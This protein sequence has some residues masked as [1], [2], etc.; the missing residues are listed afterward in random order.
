MARHTKIIRPQVFWDPGEK[1]Y[2]VKTGYSEAYKNDL[3]V[4][5]DHGVRYDGI[6]KLWFVDEDDLNDLFKVLA[7]HWPENV[8][9]K[10]DFIP[11]PDPNKRQAPAAQI[12]GAGQAALDFV[13]SDGYEGART[14]Y[15]ALVKKYEQAW[16]DANN[17]PP[18]IKEK[19]AKITRAWQELKS[20]MGWS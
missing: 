16:K 12:N 14:L 2:A 19:A 7:A 17:C 20:H 5:M 4:M 8:Y 3:K 13:A 9:G 18:E 15:R 1:K 10:V 6:N 11:K